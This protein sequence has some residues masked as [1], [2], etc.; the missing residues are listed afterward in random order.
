VKVC[1]DDLTSLGHL[2]GVHVL[3]GFAAVINLKPSLN[4]KDHGSEA[5]RELGR[6]IIVISEWLRTYMVTHLREH[7]S[8]GCG[9][10][11]ACR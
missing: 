11:N 3:L 4:V 1:H 6:V 9:P 8:I 10:T 2:W 5:W 7:N